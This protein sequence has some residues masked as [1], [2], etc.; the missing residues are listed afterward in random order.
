M[1]ASVCASTALVGSS[2]TRTSGSARRAAAST[3][4]WRCPPERLRASFGQLGLEAL[5]EALDDVTRRRRLDGFGHGRPVAVIVGDGNPEC[6]PP[7][8][9][10]QRE[11]R[12][13]IDD[14]DVLRTASIGN[15]SPGHP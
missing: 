7:G 1:S 5:R 4:R 9:M 15:V 13:A 10:S 8:R 3:T 6:R 14:Q 12:L 11:L 2:K